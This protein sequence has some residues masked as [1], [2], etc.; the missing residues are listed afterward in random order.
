MNLINLW[1]NKM[2]KDNLP[3]ALILELPEGF[4]NLKE[5]IDSFKNKQNYIL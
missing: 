5:I 2:S 3:H 4:D 1:M